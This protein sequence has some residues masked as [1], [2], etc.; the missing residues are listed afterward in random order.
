MKR[1]NWEQNPW[2]PEELAREKDYLY[3]V[4]PEAAVCVWGGEP[5]RNLSA[6]ILRGRYVVESFTVL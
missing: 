1:I 2:F 3:R 4:D 5:R 6:Q